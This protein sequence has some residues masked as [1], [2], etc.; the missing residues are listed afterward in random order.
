MVK[1]HS[2]ANLRVRELE[3]PR[4]ARLLQGS[5]A[6]LSGQLPGRHW[7][8]WSGGRGRIPQGL[9]GEADSRTLQASVFVF[10]F[11]S[12]ARMYTG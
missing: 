11:S 3:L 4:T 5:P 10:V 9:L 8:G 6:L 2:N 7:V 1:R 12:K